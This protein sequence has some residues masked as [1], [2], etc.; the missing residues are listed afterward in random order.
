MRIGVA[1]QQFDGLVALNAPIDV[2]QG[3]LPPLL[4]VVCHNL[5]RCSDAI[6]VQTVSL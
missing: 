6:I 5:F 3:Q 2:A 4:L 1:L